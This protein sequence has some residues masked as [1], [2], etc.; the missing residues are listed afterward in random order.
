MTNYGKKIQM[1]RLQRYRIHTVTE[2]N[3]VMSLRSGQEHRLF[4]GQEGQ[5]KG[6]QIET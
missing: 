6:T 4:E 2:C 1:H 3:S 5:A